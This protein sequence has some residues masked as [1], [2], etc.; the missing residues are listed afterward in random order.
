MSPHDITALP[1]TP[2]AMFTPEV[3][4]P[5]VTA[6]VMPAF[7]MAAPDESAASFH[8]A[9]R[10][11][12]G[13][14]VRVHADLLPH[15]PYE[16]VVVVIDVLRTCTVA[17]ILFDRGLASLTL[18]PSLRAARAAASEAGD[19][20]YLIGE[21]Q[22][23]PPEGFNYGNSP[24]ELARIDVA[25]R[26]AILVSENAPA[27][28][29]DVSGAQ[30][31]LLGSLYNM[32][33]V[34]NAAAGLAR[35]RVDLVCCGFGGEEDLDDALAAGTIAAE[36]AMRGAWHTEG[37]SRGA[38]GATG[39][40][41]SAEAAETRARSDRSVE[42]ARH[43]RDVQLSGA[44]RMCVSLLAAYPDP[45]DALW[46]SVAGRHLR[47]LDLEQDIGMA[48]RLSHSDVVPILSQATTRDEGELFTFAPWR[49]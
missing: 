5:D 42:R 41:R 7:E 11:P 37:G 39:D 45:L 19:G 23:L 40:S 38:G 31:V 21:R 28:L 13:R 17:P 29:P 47:R 9:T 35:E 24:V 43:Q 8:G 20:T 33:A 1:L 44:A 2:L 36:I 16:D 49:R 46:S 48:A 6:F 22:G 34:A 18:T 26:H 12:S 27:T 32:V 10:I 25:G 15:P 3:T 4:A 14:S 30:H